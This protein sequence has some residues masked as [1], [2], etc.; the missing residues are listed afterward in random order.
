MARTARI[1]TLDWK[2]SPPRTAC[3]AVTRRVAAAAPDVVSPAPCPNT[4]K[5]PSTAIAA[6][7]ART[8]RRV[9]SPTI[10]PRGS[11]CAATSLNSVVTRTRF[12]SARIL[13]AW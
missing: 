9:H 8:A 4:S 3:G 11:A 10:W 1:S 13:P 12:G 6:K 5:S 2:K 7:T